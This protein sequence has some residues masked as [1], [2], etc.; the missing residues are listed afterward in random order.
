MAMAPFRTAKPAENSR[1]I[2]R[3]CRRVAASPATPT[4]AASHRTRSRDGERLRATAA[5]QTSRSGR[6]AS[7]MHTA[8]R[9]SWPPTPMTMVQ[10]GRL[11]V[12]GWSAKPVPSVSSARA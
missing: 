7:R 8:T 6:A 9:A 3:V 10:S 12:S 5:S 1:K 4:T 11:P 2:A